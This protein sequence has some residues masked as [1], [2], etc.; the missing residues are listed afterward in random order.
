MIVP[1]AKPDPAGIK[2]SVNTICQFAQNHGLSNSALGSLLDV[3]A[4][5]ARIEQSS[6]NALLKSLYPA[7]RIPSNLICS[8]ACSLGAGKQKASAATQQGLVKWLVMV[9][10]LL[11]NP[12]IL[13]KLYSVLFNLLDVFYLRAYLCHLLA[14]ITRSKHIKP[15][16]VE[17]LRSLVEGPTKD[18]NIVKLMDVF[19]YLAPG[20]S[21]HSK[22]KLPVSFAQ[23]DSQWAKTLR[24]IWLKNGTVLP[25]GALSEN[26]TKVGRGGLT[27][28][29]S[30]AIDDQSQGLLDLESLD[31]VVKTVEKL[32]PHDLKQYYL[33]DRLL[34]QYLMLRP[35]DLNRQQV[36][37]YLKKLFDRQKEEVEEGE[38]LDRDLLEN[39]L[40]YTQ[41]AKVSSP[42]S[43]V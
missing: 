13:S 40:A 1:S 28:G 18:A 43:P 27:R 34:P 22:I 19:E 14:K 12:T 16:R 35:E 15:S 11:E 23:P 29:R 30:S 37:E 24:M 33:G 8:V 32:E 3:L 20:S 17:M 25:V 9:C 21:N 31:D 41:H 4:S 5:P 2:D 26:A 38:G 42:T 39:V 10:D 7:E 6:Q 36:D